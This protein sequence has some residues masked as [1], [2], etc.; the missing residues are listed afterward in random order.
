MTR[1][2]DSTT[3]LTFDIDIYAQRNADLTAIQE[4]LQDEPFAEFGG[5]PS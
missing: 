3:D 1:E 2:V 5:V 4:Y